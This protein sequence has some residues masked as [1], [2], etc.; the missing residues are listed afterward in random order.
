MRINKVRYRNFFSSKDT[1]VEFDKFDGIT[2]I[3]GENGTGKSILFE[4]VVWCIT[5]RS[6]RKS[7]EESMVNNQAKK[8]CCVEIWI[9]DDTYIKRT[10][11]PTSLEFIVDGEN[12][13]QEDARH[14]QAEIE[15]HLRTNYKVLLA[16]TIFGQ[17]SEVDFLGATADDKRTIIRNFLNLEDVFKIRDKIKDHKSKHNNAKKAADAALE[18]NDKQT[19][20]LKKKIEEIS[21]YG[22]VDFPDITL[23]EIVHQ[24]QKYQKLVNE[25]AEILKRR[26]V[27]IDEVNAANDIIDKGTYSKV[28]ECEYCGQ[29]YTGKVTEED[30]TKAIADKHYYQGIADDLDKA[31]A[32]ALGKAKANKPVMTSVEYSDREE[33]IQARKMLDEFKTQLETLGRRRDEISADQLKSVSSYEVMRFWE[34]A[35]SEK[36]LLQY[37]IKNVLKYFNDRCN[38]YLYHIA[39]GQ[40]YIEFDT[41]LNEVIWSEKR[42]L[43]YPS[44]SGGQ[45][46][47]IN[48]SVM[49]ALQDLLSLTGTDRTDVLFFDEIGENLSEKSLYGLYILLQELKTQ[50][51][52]IFLITHNDR[53]K[54]LL[55][56][57][58]VIN[59]TMDRGIT[60]L[61]SN[62][63]GD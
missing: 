5:G 49:L 61:T 54:S 6:I 10:R 41:E 16:S 39:N 15:K 44:L 35:F 58:S 11:K 22:D 51:K 48:L 37:I 8:D 24:E 1:E 57:T 18:E 27:A 3:D 9:N 38:T 30:V 20:E 34:T 55:D 53:L 46:R 13:T 19:K 2:L 28:D 29:Y 25:A 60:K 63:D 26:I 7:T 36:G 17:H 56:F 33:A 43:L 21:E 47:M 40:Y 62:R 52:K 31:H 59:V 14:T 4:A 42:K 50:G 32:E 12:L 45:K 23:M